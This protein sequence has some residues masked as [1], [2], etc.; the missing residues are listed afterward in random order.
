MEGRTE[1]GMMKRTTTKDIWRTERKSGRKMG[2]RKD[3]R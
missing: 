3:G 2:K 1:R